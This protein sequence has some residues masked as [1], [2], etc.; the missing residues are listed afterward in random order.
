MPSV[1][2]YFQVHQPLR[3]RKYRVFDVGQNSSYFND[4]SGTSL[5]NK[6]IIEKVAR[7]CYLPANAVLL[8]NIKNNP[9][10]KASFSV[11][12]VA[13][14]QFEK[15]APDVIESFKALVDTGNVELLSETYYHSL[16][17]IYSEEEFMNQVG[18]H[19][20]KVHDL[21][22][23]T[24]SVFR[25]TELI[26]SNEIAK[27]AEK[28]GY[29][30]IL[31]EGADHVLGWRSP[32]FVY[33]PTGTD[34]IK[35]LLKHYRLSDD[36]AFRFSQRSW[37]GWPLT[38][39]K[40]ADWVSSHNGN[41]NTINL[42][43]DYETFGEHQ[44]EDTG[45]F[46]FLRYLPGEILKNPDNNFATPSEVI[47]RYEAK[48]ELDVPYHVS[49]ADTE[50]DLSAWIGNDLQRQALETIYAL[51]DEI[52]HIDDPELI[53]DWRRLQTSDHF[54]YMCTK[55]WNDG[56]VHKYFSPYE[57]PYEAFIAYMNVLQDLRLRLSDA[58][59]RQE[60]E[61]ALRKVKPLRFSEV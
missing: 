20:K 32:T 39:P 25:N 57:S 28:M 1:C 48:G 51:G 42:F 44:W 8:E 23:V 56:D 34:N 9:E 54:Y 4:Q 12:G 7:K 22:G 58:K 18:L 52:V 27:M 31:A 60:Y 53:E 11:S 55:W 36:V 5:D 10:F 38:A 26:Y 16:A 43:M 50:R 14:E 13:L 24:P 2:F 49:W 15:Y 37:E 19:R 21:F 6:A 30:G 35:L 33:K 61:I 40:F 59:K 3:V 29:K 45:I 47:D 46:E 17:S 41:G